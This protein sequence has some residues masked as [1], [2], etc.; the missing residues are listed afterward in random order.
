[1]LWAAINLKGELLAI[2]EGTVEDVITFI[3]GIPQVAVC[4]NSPAGVSAQLISNPQIRATLN[5]QPRAGK[6][7]RFRVCE[8]L[9]KCRNIRLIPASAKQDQAPDWMIKGFA[10]FN[11]LMKIDALPVFE[12][13]AHA[14]FCALL[15]R[16]PFLKQTSEGQIQRQLVLIQAGLQLADPLNYYEEITRRKLLQGILPDGKIYSSR[17]LDALVSALN[18]RQQIHFPDEAIILGEPQEG[19]ISLPVKSLKDHYH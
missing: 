9:L 11:G 15:G 2:R 16:I 17:E 6:Y 10:L 18:A 1:M 5:P 19:Q 12:T 7:S 14:A 13:N 4:I 3:R 8:Y